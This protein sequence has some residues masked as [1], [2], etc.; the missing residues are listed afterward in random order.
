MTLPER[1]RGV[2]DW[3]Q[4]DET[5]PCCKRCHIKN[6]ECAYV[7]E[8]S[9]SPRAS[10][11][12]ALEQSS[13]DS[14]P[15]S[16][17]DSPY[18]CS[19]WNTG[20]RNPAGVPDAE[21]ARHYLTHTVRTLSRSSISESQSD[22]WRIFIP[23]LALTCPVVR[24]GMLVLG[25]MSLHFDST[26]VPT[27]RTDASW[28]TSKYSD[29]AEAHG[30]I[31]VRESRQK[32]QD[33][34][35]HAEFDASFACSRLLCLLGFAFFRAHRGNGVTLA[36]SAAWTWLQLLRGVKAT[37]VAILESG[38]GVA[39]MA[40]RDTVLKPLS[41]GRPLDTLAADIGPGY[42]H[43]SFPFFTLSRHERFDALRTTLQE[44]WLS[45]GDD[46]VRD[47]GSAID[48]LWQVTEHV[49]SQEVHSLF[50]AILF[51]PDSVSKGF[52]DMLTNGC[53]PALAV[54]AHWLMLVVLVEDL[55]WVD[56]M[57]RSGIR[58]IINMCSDA[59]SDVRVLLR[60]P[61]LMLAMEDI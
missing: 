2:D 48:L 53:P 37:Y 42:K 54:Y 1:E 34:H 50:R 39:E 3:P 49:C 10:K 56:N 25:A 31:F 47:L 13:R 58:E 26:A 19:A 8:D 59:D 30:V 23:A 38:Q 7:K 9:R 60:W 6:L 15:P 35:R 14:K 33:L 51:W 17:C 45:L 44:S 52:V 18:E 32:L 29:A 27:V 4:C 46:K 43:A 41:T 5:R 20:V 21:L 11:G 57:G 36:D 55:W 12:V 22:V 16:P 28:H 24:R 61:Q 40:V